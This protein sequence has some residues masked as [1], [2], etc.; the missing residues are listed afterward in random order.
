ME[1]SL[2]S[3]KSPNIPLL[4]VADIKLNPSNPN[5][6]FLLTGDGD[7]ILPNSGNFAHGQQESRSIGILK[8]IDGGNT[9][10][11]TNFL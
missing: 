7:A 2:G 6:V 3:N 1:E 10:Y 11:P 5:E 4:A 9:W 8:S